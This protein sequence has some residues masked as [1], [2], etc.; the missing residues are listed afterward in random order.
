M[1]DSNQI[2]FSRHIICDDLTRLIRENLPREKN[3]GHLTDYPK[4]DYV[5]R[6][7]DEGNSIFFLQSGQVAV[8]NIDAKGHEIIIRLIGEGE[9]FGELCLCTEGNGERRTS[10]CAVIPSEVIEVSVD[11][12]INFLQQNHES[13]KNLLFTCCVRLAEAEHRI[14]VLAYRGAE[15][16]LGKLLLSLASTQGEKEN[17]GTP[18]DIT[19]AVS[20][21]DLAQMAA[22]SRAHTTVTM[23][24]FRKQGIVRYARGQPVTVD[25][26]ALTKFLDDK[27]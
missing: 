18:E 19:L 13:L 4:G 27:R 8:K 11:D 3:F 20:H 15:E 25:V 23:G 21:E 14:E 24:K 22:M 12:F 10:A 16:R 17:N 5:L 1:A 2:Y 9:P 6:Q 26:P 7:G